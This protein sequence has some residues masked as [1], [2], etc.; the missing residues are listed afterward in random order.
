[1]TDNERKLQEMKDNLREEYAG[2][3]NA[4]NQQIKQ[5]LATLQ[6]SYVHI[7]S[8]LEINQKRRLSHKDLEDCKE[9]FSENSFKQQKGGVFQ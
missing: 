8:T 7:D 5:D 6:D 3:N 9:F 2:L 4:Q 1:M